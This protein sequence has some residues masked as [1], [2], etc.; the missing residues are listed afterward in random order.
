MRITERAR[1]VSEA[2]SYFGIW[3]CLTH[4][5][6][7][8]S[9]ATMCL[10]NNSKSYILRDFFKLKTFC[11]QRKKL[12]PRCC[13]SNLLFS[14]AKSNHLVPP[15]YNLFWQREEYTGHLWFMRAI[16]ILP[17]TIYLTFNVKIWS[18]VYV[19]IVDFTKL[20]F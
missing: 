14:P 11:S 16:A 8:W 9:L 7:I 10:V 20:R 19:T 3:K 18:C 4:K 1:Y 6:R 12:F 2:K 17:Q 15:P 13:V 5:N